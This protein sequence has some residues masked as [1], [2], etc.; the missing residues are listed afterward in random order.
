MQGKT[1]PDAEARQKIETRWPDVK[2]NLWD[3]VPKSASSPI[4]EPPADPTGHGDRSFKDLILEHAAVIDRDCSLA[5][6]EGRAGDYIKLMALK[7][8]VLMDGAKFTGELTAAEESR[9]TKSNRF[10]Q[11]R[12]AIAKALV[13]FPDASRAVEEALRAVD[14]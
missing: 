9:L 8:K 13:H 10:I 3:V 2:P 4:H 6:S 12:T 11:I 1:K 5:K 14:A 7:Q